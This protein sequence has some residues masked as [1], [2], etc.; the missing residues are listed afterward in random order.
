MSK[1][2]F[3]HS[4]SDEHVL[5]KKATVR[6]ILDESYIDKY[7]RFEIEEALVTDEYESEILPDLDC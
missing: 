2:N 3:V 7:S 1:Q 5:L 6:K 4:L